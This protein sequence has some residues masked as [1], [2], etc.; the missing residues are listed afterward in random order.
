M[1][2]KTAT[3]ASPSI[4]PDEIARFSALADE[5][6]DPEGRFRPLHK[7]NPVRLACIRDH[8]AGHFD[9]DPLKKRPFAGLRVLDIGC[10][11]GL[12]SEPLARLGAEVVAIDASAENI[13]T[14]RAHAAQSGL[15]IDYRHATAEELAAAGETF[16][17]VLALEIVE[18]VADLD[19][20]VT[21]M[22][23]LVKPDGMLAVATLNRT[24]QA[25]LLGIVGAEY[26]LRWL[27]RGTHNW[28]KFIRPS[29]LA[30]ALRRHG[31]SVSD[32]TGVAYSLL[33]DSWRTTDDLSVNYMAFAVKE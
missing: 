19:A 4:D 18:H 27:P 20:F 3:A 26:V 6:W 33:A 8:L 28:Q 2:I 23:A 22:A 11:G 30:S 24:P 1:A 25:F 29:E 14:A 32:L 9:R 31:L 7:F 15:A 13:G 17:A 5:W 12:V 21:A 16:E 10:G